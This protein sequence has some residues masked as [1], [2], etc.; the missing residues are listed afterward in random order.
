MESIKREREVS[1]SDTLKIPNGKN[2]VRFFYDVRFT[3][4]LSPPFSRGKGFFVE[5]KNVSN[6]SSIKM[7]MS[8]VMV[9]IILN[10]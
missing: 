8:K 1:S 7:K 4:I 6:A 3:Y 2:F 5:K 9:I 10:L